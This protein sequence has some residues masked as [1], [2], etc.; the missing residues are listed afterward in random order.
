MAK[1][2]HKGYKL[3]SKVEKFTVGIDNILDQKLVKHDCTASVAY[4]KMLGQK[5]FLTEKETA[6]IISELQSVAELAKK[7]KFRIKKS[8][9]DC[10][11]AIENHL[12]QKLGDAGKKIHTGRSRNEQVLVA[13]RLYYREELENC[14]ALSESLVAKIDSFVE[15]SGDVLLPGYTHMQKAMPS[16]VGMWAE[17]F[18]DSMEDN[19]S[20]IGS[21]AV[22][23]DQC[24]LGTGAGYG[25]P[26]ESDREFLAEE[27]GFLHPQENPIYCQNS[28]GKFESTILHAISQIMADLNR[29]ASDLLLF[30][31]EEYGFFSLPE[32]FLTGSSMM[33]HKMNPDVLELLRAKYHVVLGLELQVK[34]LA[35]NLPSGYSRDLQLTKGAVM[36]AFEVAKECLGIA[37]LLFDG[38]RVNGEKCEG[39]ISEGMLSVQESQNLVKKGI[40]FRDAYRQIA[41]NSAK[42]LKY[43]DLSN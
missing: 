20:L 24:P 25:S 13:L 3:D 18:A 37:G 43:D 41:K 10:H 42:N 15:K 27:L 38:L 19:L 6:S 32:N 28:R 2:W 34:G 30:T 29:I 22:L 12:V 39:A 26:I 8:D 16:S 7:G 40:P 1:L 21:A 33:P 35:S 14:R 9:E 31:T 17:S 23:I 4:A 11:T 36:E 5:G